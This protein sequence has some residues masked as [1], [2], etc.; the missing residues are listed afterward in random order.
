MFLYRRKIRQ[1]DLYTE[2][3]SHSHLV[4]F[5]TGKFLHRETLNTANSNFHAE[6]LLHTQLLH[7]ASFYTEPAV[8]QSQLLHRETLT[9]VMA[10]EIAAPKADL[11]AKA[12]KGG[13]WSTFSEE[14]YKKNHRCQD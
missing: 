14:L 12:K 3:L 7:G 4:S 5:Y 6:K 13:F 1:K 9:H 8:T 10:T 11:D 2:T